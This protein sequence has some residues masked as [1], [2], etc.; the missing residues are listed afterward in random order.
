MRFLVPAACALSMAAAAHADGPVEL[1]APPEDGYA[2]LQDGVALLSCYS[3]ER[4]AP[5]SSRAVLLDIPGHER[6]GFDVLLASRHGVMDED[7]PRSC[8]IRG[9]EEDEGAIARIIAPPDRH[10]VDFVDDWA[11]LVTERR[12]PRD[13]PRLRAAGFV[14]PPRGEI[15]IVA[16][17]A[18]HHPCQLTEGPDRLAHEALLF[19]DC[20]S[21]AGLSGTPLVGEI[22]GEPFVIGVH[23]GR[24]RLLPANDQSWSV[25]RRLNGEFSDALIAVVEEERR[26]RSRQR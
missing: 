8:Q 6:A 13:L 21:R 2:S 14:Q 26:R 23:L 25:A 10:E 24:A 22:D 11:V 4:E 19:H 7:Q 5:R 15:A 16:R 1:N 3:P 18:E 12:L 9:L 17:A 20:P